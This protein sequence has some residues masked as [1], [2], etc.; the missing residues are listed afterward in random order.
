MSIRWLAVSP[1]LLLPMAGTAQKQIV[2]RGAQ[3]YPVVNF[4]GNIAYRSNWDPG[5]PHFLS[6]LEDPWSSPEFL[7]GSGPAKP[8]DPG[9]DGM[10]FA[11]NETRAFYFKFEEDAS[12]APPSMGFYSLGQRMEIPPYVGSPVGF[13]P[14]LYR[15]SK[16]H[17][18]MTIGAAWPVYWGHAWSEF[19]M[20]GWDVVL[21]TNGWSLIFDQGGDDIEPSVYETGASTYIAWTSRRN[22]RGVLNGRYGVSVYLVDSVGHSFQSVLEELDARHPNFA[23][24]ETFHQPALVYELL[25]DKQTPGQPGP[26]LRYAL[27]DLSGNVLEHDMLPTPCTAPHRPVA[28]WFKGEVYVLYTCLDSHDAELRLMSLDGKCD[29][30]IDYLGYAPSD[31]EQAQYDIAGEHIVYSRWLGPDPW[32]LDIFW[33]VIPNHC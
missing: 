33:T 18:W 31:N 23:K 32:D 2:E 12:G 22:E 25:V 3:Q 6:W 17:R 26:L 15:T 10:F 16:R 24:S 7:D 8:P 4:K 20:G 13:D 21:R 27:F 5:G 11:M 1:V 29:V 30:T 28:T 14:V 19:I 9:A